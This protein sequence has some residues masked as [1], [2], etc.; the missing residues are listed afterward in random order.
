[1]SRPRINVSDNEVWGRLV[2]TWATGKNYVRHAITEASPF[3]TV[4]ETPPE[5]PK[6]TSF[7]DFVTQCTKAG[8]TLFFEDGVN[9]PPVSANEPMGFVL[10]QVTSDTAVL[11]LPAKEKI[12]ESEQNLLVKNYTLPQFYTRVFGS[13]P[14]AQNTL[15]KKAVLHSER[16]G[17]YTINTCA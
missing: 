15:T 11:R 5:F 6:P 10:L 13:A 2:K 9:N 1:M 12:E 7:Q 17:E 8:V 4:V 16:V 3:P 14:Q